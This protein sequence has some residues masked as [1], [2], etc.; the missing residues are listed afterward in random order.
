MTSVFQIVCKAMVCCSKAILW[1][2]EALDENSPDKVR[3]PLMSSQLK[4]SYLAV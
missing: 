2:L 4:S 3:S 1:F